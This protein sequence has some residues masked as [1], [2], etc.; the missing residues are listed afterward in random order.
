[1]ATQDTASDLD[2]LTALLG[3]G[4]FA[5]ADPEVG[6]FLRTRSLMSRLSVF[7]APRVM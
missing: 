2:Q 4:K 1:M 3:R 6:K 5:T 7:L